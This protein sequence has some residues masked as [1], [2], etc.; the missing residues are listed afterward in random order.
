MLTC[1]TPRRIWLRSHSRVWS[2]IVAAGAFRKHIYAL[3]EGLEWF[4]NF[5]QLVWIITVPCVCLPCLPKA[6]VY[7]AVQT[8]RRLCE[9]YIYPNTKHPLIPIIEGLASASAWLIAVCLHWQAMHVT[10]RP[11]VVSYLVHPNF[12]YLPIPSK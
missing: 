3:G 1:G 5:Y 10:Q 9:V 4:K 6:R 11:P 7:K 2:S 12:T 8:M